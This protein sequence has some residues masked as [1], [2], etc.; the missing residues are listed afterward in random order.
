LLTELK[1]AMSATEFHDAVLG[2]LRLTD[3]G[4]WE[5]NVE[6]N[7]KT[8]GFGIGGSMQPDSVLIVHARDIVHSFDQFDRMVAEFL[9]SEANRLSGAA[10]EIR[11]L[12]MED[13]ILYWPK[14]PND[15]MIY[16]RGPDPYRG[17]RCDYIA[18]K[19]QALGFDD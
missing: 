19:P 10:H 13:V 2:P 6:I 7:G 3:G 16:F 18:G 12:V 5:A 4:W 17:W 8:L 14:R 1:A 15:G 9:A 11:Q